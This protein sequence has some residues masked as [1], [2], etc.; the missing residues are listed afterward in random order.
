MEG[1]VT[2]RAARQW[3]YCRSKRS[4]R[5]DVTSKVASSLF[6]HNVYVC[7]AMFILFFNIIGIYL[8]LVFKSPRNCKISSLKIFRFSDDSLATHPHHHSALKTCDFFIV[9]FV[10]LLWIQKVLNVVEL[11][12]HPFQQIVFFFIIFF[13]KS[14]IL[15]HLFIYS[16]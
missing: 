6:Q 10:L 1:T 8:Q 11:A 14:I 13:I 12:K 2:K 4:F 7:S 9:V 5:Y 15:F 3:R 16:R